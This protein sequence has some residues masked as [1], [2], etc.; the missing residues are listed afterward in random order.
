M[1]TYI[2]AKFH[3][4]ILDGIEVKERT[5]FLNEKFQRAIIMQKMKVEF[6]F[7]FSAHRLIVVYIC[8]NFHEN[9]L[10]GIKIIEQ[11]LFLKEKFQRAIIP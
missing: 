8:T 5:P 6:R 3:E 9:I 10:N 11:T 7:F 1:V 4:N 2:C